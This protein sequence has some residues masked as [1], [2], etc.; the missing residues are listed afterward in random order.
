MCK[1]AFYFNN[2]TCLQIPDCTTFYSLIINFGL[3]LI[4]FNYLN[5]SKAWNKFVLTIK[6]PCHFSPSSLSALLLV[7]NKPQ[8]LVVVTVGKTS[9][10]LLRD[11]QYKIEKATCQS[12]TVLWRRGYATGRSAAFF[13]G[14][15]VMQLNARFKAHFLM[16]A[17]RL[18]TVGNKYWLLT[19][20]FVE[21]Y[22][23]K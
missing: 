17:V 19:C 15:P 11:A 2:C 6:T 23:L 18:I 10:V 20:S 22:S 9:D 7:A 13:T 21:Y 16:V 1:N 8:L 5:A 12:V 14:K 3:L 4:R